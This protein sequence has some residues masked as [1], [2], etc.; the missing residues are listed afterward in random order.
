MK[1]SLV[2]ILW[3]DWPSMASTIAIPIFFGIY[4]FHPWLFKGSESQ[5]WPIYFLAISVSSAIFIILLRISSIHSLFKAHN[6]TEGVIEYLSIVKDRGRLEYSF[7]IGNE[8]INSWSPVHKTKHVL[9]FNSGDV[10]T[11]LYKPN[12]ASKSLI[13][14]LYV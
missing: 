7:M 6:E 5:N 12:N 1:P 10:V 11:I 14:E 8:R 2:K 13:K 9:S 3:N 4:L